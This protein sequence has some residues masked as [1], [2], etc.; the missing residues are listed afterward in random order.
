MAVSRLFG[1]S[2]KR[3]EDPRL[4]TGRGL[5]TDDVKIQG[6]LYAAFV[7]SPHGHAWVRRIDTQRAA[8]SPGV[9][10]VLT[11]RDIE[12]KVGPVPCA[13]QIPNADL[14]VPT[15]RPLALEKV[16]YA[17]DPVAVVVAD[18]PYRARDAAE[19][20]EVEYERLPAV[21]SPEEAARQGA[22]Q[23][24]DEVPGNVAF[25]WSMS[26]GDVDS[27][28][29][30][31]EVVVRQRLLNNRLIPVAMEP[32]GAVAA[33]NGATGELT[34]WMT[35]QNPHIHR[36]LLSVTLGIPEHRVR[37]ISQDV[38]GG[39][40]SK[41]HFYGAE[42]VVS[43][44]SMLLGRPVKWMEDRAENMSATAHGRD[45][46]TY[47]ELAARRSGE[48]LG[49][50]VTT[51]ANLGA[52][53]STAA[54]GIP[55]ILYGL[56]LSGPYR[57]PAVRCEVYGVL[58]NTM[59]VDAYRGAGRPEATYVLE[60]MMDILAYQLGL[61]PAE[62]RRRNL[63]PPFRDQYQVSTGLSY[64]SGNYA[65]ALEKALEAA[66]Y[67]RLREEQ[68]RLRREGR[69][70]GVGISTYVEIC[71]LGPSRVV[72]STGFGLGLWESCT[73]R[74]HP[75]GKV[76]V[77]TGGH[78]HGQGEET[79]FA[80]IAADALGV[81][82]EDVEIIHG[83]T[84]QVPFGMG[85]YGSRTTPVAG[86]AVARCA[87]KIIEKARQIASGILETRVEDIEFRDGRFYVKETPERGVT[88][89]EV[90]LNAYTADKLPAGVE[91]GLEE[92]VFYDPPNFTFPFGAHVCVAEVDEETGA[93]R[94]LRYV[95]VDDCGRVI[96]PMIVEGQ[97][98][99]GVTQGLSQALY[100]E[101]VYSGDGTL[102][103]SSL[104]DYLIPSSAEVPLYEAQRTETP[105]PTNPLGIKGVGE[106]G[107]IASTPAVVNAVIDA[108]S[109]R[110][111][112]HIDPP[113]TPARI[114]K[115]LHTSR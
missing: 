30:S 80:Q 102:L 42:A 21:V 16:R 75:S 96:N 5:F 74:V 52:Y 56:M 81:P 115:E 108:L 18:D 76:S 34:V 95:A 11:G 113:L 3:R 2:V 71:G 90:A 93:V 59:A 101:A 58:T 7:R 105:S 62:V 41:I 103:T 24:Y 33:Y 86:V 77:F 67:T 39:F 45:H 51:Y 68:A 73:I 31:A 4:I 88:F 109:H 104:N 37:V 64:D 26:S 82:L 55:T 100:E 110:G 61:D 38:G 84:G 25:R 40:G 47:A 69:L 29:S 57:I 63:I 35:S 13:W 46:V 91:P 32:R 54:P 53:L 14:K 78:P 106:T 92:T 15:Y 44:L 85:T 23:L 9:V 114:W 99:G 98:H 70:L 48:V 111:I 6:M 112:R 17:G 97:V 66:G 83:D 65:A 43:Y 60:R 72:R 79:T 87:E 27:A 20:V 19:L 89:Q 10:A 50:R 28:F 1:A 36:F 22:P 107:T 8:K 49:L 12:G 94:V